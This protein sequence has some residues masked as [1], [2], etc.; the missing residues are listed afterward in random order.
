MKLAAILCQAFDDSHNL[1]SVFK[2]ISIVGTVLERPKIKE[3][4]TFK[5]QQ[6][7]NMLDD[8]MWGWNL[9]VYEFDFLNPCILDQFVKEFMNDL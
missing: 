5:Y 6:I 9:K 8:E 2:L 3:E 1:E 4:F 7:L